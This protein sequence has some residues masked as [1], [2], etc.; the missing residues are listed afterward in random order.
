M[1]YCPADTLSWTS[2]LENYELTDFHC[3][4]LLIFGL[5]LTAA[6]ETNTTSSLLT[7]DQEEKQS[8]KSP[9]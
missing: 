7:I 1:D 5:S 6:Q 4:K 2:C 8:I 9:S 3:F